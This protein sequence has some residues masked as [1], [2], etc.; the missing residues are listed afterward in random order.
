MGPGMP[1]SLRCFIWCSTPHLSFW[2]Y[3]V[4][5]IAFWV[6]F[7]NGS[8]HSENVIDDVSAKVGLGALALACGI[9]LLTFLNSV[10]AFLNA[11]PTETWNGW[12]VILCFGLSVLL[13]IVGVG[14]IRREVAKIRVTMPHDAFVVNKC[15]GVGICGPARRKTSNVVPFR[16]GGIP[17]KTVRGAILSTNELNP[18]LCTC[19]TERAGVSFS[20][21]GFKHWSSKAWERSATVATAGLGVVA[22]LPSQEAVFPGWAL[23]TPKGTIVY[24]GTVIVLAVAGVFCIW[25]S[26]DVRDAEQKLRDD[27]AE[28]NHSKAMGNAEE[29]HVKAM[30]IAD[31]QLAASLEMV[32]IQKRSY[33]LLQS[34]AKPDAISG[35]G[36]LTIVGNIGGAGVLSGSGSHRASGR[37]DVEIETISRSNLILAKSAGL[38]AGFD[39]VETV[40]KGTIGRIPAILAEY[41]TKMIAPFFSWSEPVPPQIAQLQKLI[42]SALADPPTEPGTTIFLG[43]DISQLAEAIPT[44]QPSAPSSEALL[45][46]EPAS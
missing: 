1:C 32:D 14:R 42:D 12:L 6:T 19:C 45:P 5:R 20:D 39:I 13:V 24:W 46:T 18:L 27:H 40:M 41:R 23:G 33:A 30:A 36:G 3:C 16:T 25:R 37:K 9:F 26:G 10:L 29:R 4:L 31:E 28:A 11:A 43:R 7:M 34:V 2:P 8:H 38:D 35:S 15:L 17:P 22:L 44:G 21:M